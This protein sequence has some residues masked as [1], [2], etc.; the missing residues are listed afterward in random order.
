MAVLGRMSWINLTVQSPPRADSH[1]QS[2]MFPDKLN[3]LEAITDWGSF[4]YLCIQPFSENEMVRFFSGLWKREN[5]WCHAGLS[6][7]TFGERRPRTEGLCFKQRQGVW[8]TWEFSSHRDW[9]ERCYQIAL[10]EMEGSGVFQSSP[11]LLFLLRPSW[12]LHSPHH[13]LYRRRD[14]KISRKHKYYASL[15]YFQGLH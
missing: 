14:W 5:G 3:I 6:R 15:L 11:I 1:L 4:V 13:H 9:N 7:L 2:Q 12:T 8:K 10:K